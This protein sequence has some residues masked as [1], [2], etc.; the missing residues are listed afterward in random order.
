[1]IVDISGGH[2]IPMM[3]INIFKTYEIL[4]EEGR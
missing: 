4:H 3:T 1:M 2:Q